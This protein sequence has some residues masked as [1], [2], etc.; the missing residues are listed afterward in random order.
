MLTPEEMTRVGPGNTKA[1][2]RRAAASLSR[3]HPSPVIRS[4]GFVSMKWMPKISWRGKPKG[5]YSTVL[6]NGSRDR[7][8]GL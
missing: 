4:P 7:T 3:I 1:V 5:R 8:A 2:S 6:V